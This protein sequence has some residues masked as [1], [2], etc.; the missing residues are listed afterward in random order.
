[1][2]ASLGSSAYCPA[3][4]ANGRNCKTRHWFCRVNGRTYRLSPTKDNKWQLHRVHSTAEEE[5]GTVLG[6]YQRRG[7]ATKAVGEM[8]YLP[9]PK[10]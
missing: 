8:A 2:N 1:M 4:I 7:D 5:K 6:K 10:W 3:P 9:E